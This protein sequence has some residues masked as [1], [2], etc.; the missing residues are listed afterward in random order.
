MGEIFLADSCG[1]DRPEPPDLPVLSSAGFPENFGWARQPVF[2]CDLSLSRSP[3]RRVYS[4]DRYIVFNPTHTIVFELRDDGFF[5]SMTVTLVSLRGKKHGT[6]FFHS[7]LPLG[8]YA[9]PGDSRSGHVRY[10]RGG[11]LLDF[12][13]MQGGSRI[14][15][16]DIPRSGGRRGVRGELVL[17]EPDGGRAQSIVCNQGWQGEAGAFRYSRCSPWY[18]PEGVVQLGTTEIVFARGNSWAVFD[19]SRGSRPRA[20]TCRW[21]CGCGLSGGRLVGFSIGHGSEDGADANA[22]FV[23]GKLHKLDRVSFRTPSSP[24]FSPWY[25]SEKAGHLAMEFSPQDWHRDRW[26][27]LFHSSARRQFF[28]SFSGRA[29]LENGREISFG[30]I[31]GFAEFAKTVF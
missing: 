6:H 7:L 12:A 19:W 2:S 27:F 31:S 13:A 1:E 17:S 30:N 8:S 9:M 4:A 16:I 14:I 10:R 20:D 25:F 18:T 5:G 24:Q 26:Q 3:A 29:I 11:V 22:L 15:R 23:D 21:V 28:G